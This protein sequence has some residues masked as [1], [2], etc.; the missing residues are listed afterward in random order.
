[1][2]ISR[3]TSGC[4]KDFG[5]REFSNQKKKGRTTAVDKADYVM[6]FTMRVC[7]MDVSP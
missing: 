1:M 2:G 6:A 7:T 5:R 4:V 3:P